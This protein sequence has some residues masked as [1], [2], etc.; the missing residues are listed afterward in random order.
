MGPA[1]LARRGGRPRLRPGRSVGDGLRG[2]RRSARSVAAAHRPPRGADPAPGQGHQLLVD[3]SSR[4]RGPLL[5]DLLRP[6]SRLW[7][8][9][10]PGHGRRP[11]RGDLEP[12]V[13][14]V[15]D[16][17]RPV[18]VRLRYRRRTPCEEHRHRHGAGARRVHQAGCGQH[19]RDRPGASGPR[20]GGRAVGSHLRC[21][22]R[23]RRALP[24][25]GRPRAFLAHAARRRRHPLQRRARV[26]PA[27]PDAARDPLDAPSRRGRAHLRRALRG[28]PR[29]DEGCLSRGRDGLGA[30]LPVR[31]RGGGDVPAHAGVRIGDPRRVARHLQGGRAILGGR[32]GSLPAA[33]HL[34][35]PDRP[36]ARDRRGG[37]PDRRP[38]GVRHAD[39]G[40][41][42]PSE[43]RRALPEEAARRHECL[44]RPARAGRDGLHR[45][46]GPGDRI[47]GARHP[48]GRPP[49]RPR[50]GRA[51]RGGGA[52]RDGAV[53]RVG[54]SGRR[55]RRHHRARLRARGARRPAAG[56][57]THQSHRR[58]ALRRGRRGSARDVG[59]G[60]GQPSRRTP[61]AF[62]DSPRP[63]GAARHAGQD[64]H[65]GGFAQPRRLHAIRLLVE[66]GAVGG[67]PDRDRGDRQQRRAGQPRGA[68][69]GPSARRG[70][71]TGRDGPV[72]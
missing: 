16:H 14:A 24:R 3:G 19:V 28:I 9:R 32:I 72:R 64:G 6:R 60:R 22:P 27:P 23:G 29:C 52:R 61:G 47:A 66:P 69:P 65:A 31:P 15:R 59:G 55:Q 17:Q 33:R 1:D 53:R 51:D 63:R 71:G 21:R 46:L 13:H 10:G 36:H 7:R 35:I 5:G 70:E 43:G 50:D 26:H 2:G 30:H 11:I 68:D 20:Q 8:R 58:G 45:L 4:P 67:D 49:R 34:R 42:R 62:G 25:R 56:P 40:A 39:G 37:R 18:E 12:R 48:R 44:P 54:R 38:R 41:A 57:R